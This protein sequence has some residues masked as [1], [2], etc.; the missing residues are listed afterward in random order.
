MTI[1]T[2]LILTGLV[3]VGVALSACTQEAANDA[4]HAT[5]AAIDS[6]KRATDTA[7][8]A[9]RDGTAK[10]I[11]DTREAGERA[12]DETRNIAQRTGDKTKEIAEKTGDKAK[13]L[14][15][16]TGEVIT[17]GWI[18]T[19]VSARFVD[20]SVLKGSRIDVDTN[21]HVVTLK[22]TVRSSTAKARAVA[23]ARGTEGVT[24]VVDQLVVPGA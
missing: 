1:L 20:E 24:S 10:A 17:D 18:T 22:G 16:T 12:E 19:K 8:D 23:I 11:E 6:T 21:N 5:S 15:S 2:S 14:V 7:L 3:G 9:T 4:T 13:E